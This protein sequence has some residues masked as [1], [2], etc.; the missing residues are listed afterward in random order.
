[1]IHATKTGVMGLAAAVTM[2]WSAPVLAGDQDRSG[3]DI[4][5][6]GRVDFAEGR[7]Y[8]VLDA[9]RDGR[10]SLDE[11][12]A[13]DPNL[14]PGEYAD[15]DVNLDGKVTRDELGLAAEKLGSR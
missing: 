8:A 7:H 13:A 11:L 5:R 10:Y 6:D 4:T 9:N 1:M 14:T 15:F 2:L 12:R 3:P